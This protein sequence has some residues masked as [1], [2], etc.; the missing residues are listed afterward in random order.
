M[1]ARTSSS[2]ARR[3]LLLCVLAAGAAAVAFLVAFGRI[4]A[5][6]AATIT[7]LAVFGSGD[8]L[9][10]VRTE[11]LGLP[12]GLGSLLEV[13]TEIEGDERV[14]RARFLG[15]IERRAAWR[16]GLGATRLAA[17][18][19][20]EATT[21]Q[22]AALADLVPPLA[23]DE[24]WPRGEAE[25][26]APLP[27][28]TR[29]AVEAALAHAFVEPES[30]R[31][32]GTHAV[33]VVQD[34]RL[35]AERYR[36]GYD[37]HTPLLG[38]SMTK[39]VMN[40]LAGILVK[41]GR[42]TL[43][44][45]IAV[46]EWRKPDDARRAI[47]LDHLLRMS[48]GLRF[49]E[50][51]VTPIPDVL[52]MLLAVADMGG[53]AADMPLEAPPG[54]RWQYSSGTTLVLARAMRH[55]IGNDDEYHAMPRRVLFERIGMTSAVI[56]TDATGTFVGSSLMY[57]T[58]RDWARFGVLYLQ[59]GV[60]NGERILPEGWVAY[61]RTPAPA[62]RS[63]RYG[64]HFWL[65][66]AEGYNSGVAELPADAFHATGHQ[67]QFVTIVPSRGVVVVRLGITRDRDAWDQPAF[68]KEVLEALER[69]R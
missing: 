29:A 14:A 25:E 61:S 20:L 4:A 12:L 62:D 42:W 39:S 19:T 52:Q 5:G 41:D 63:R 60:W 50:E 55:L 31:S 28:G 26:L 47:T 6:Y 11:R 32:R 24:P 8:E 40:A 54:T 58:A 13:A 46:P 45:P 16:A 10:T 48:S 53:Y 59:D 37:R 15:L 56:E 27:S 43:D 21:L 22:P 64:A 67:G 68:V 7:A 34:G 30:G 1:S 66:V 36:P 17:G 49:Q 44:G 51:M 3:L 65:Q 2:K 33:V 35:V 57:A 23:E 69:D 18:A 38:W 9:A